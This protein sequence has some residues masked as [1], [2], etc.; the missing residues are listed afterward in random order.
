MVLVLER[1]LKI[2]ILSVAESEELRVGS[3]SFVDQGHGSF[4]G[5]HDWLRNPAMPHQI[6]GVR[7]W[8]HE[9][10]FLPK[11]CLLD[12]EYVSPMTTGNGFEIYFQANRSC[13]ERLSG[14]QSFL[15]N[16]VLVSLEQNVALVLDI[17]CLSSNEARIC[18]E[19]FVFT[20]V[21]LLNS[22]K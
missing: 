8:P 15:F 10:T 21:Q 12:R 13:D 9:K 1:S 22:K 18:R 16:K 14:D 5:F 19:K 20:D 11:S 2:G 4:M 3:T 6:I 7:F 17:G